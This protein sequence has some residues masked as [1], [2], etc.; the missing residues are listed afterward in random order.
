MEIIYDM[1]AKEYHD[2]PRFSSSGIKKILVSA[3]DFWVSSWMNPNRKEQTSD[4]FNV[5]TAYHTRILEGEEVFD[6]RYAV[7]PDVDRRTKDGK[8]TYLAWLEANPEA[9]A[10]DL[11][12]CVQIE[13][14]AHRL[15]ETKMFSDG[16]P[17]VSILWTDDETGVPMKARLDY[18]TDSRILDLKT[19]SNSQGSDIMRLVANHMIKYRYH[20]QAAIYNGLF[21]DREMLFVFQQTGDVN[22]FIVRSLPQETLI[23]DQGRK[24]ARQG[25]RKFA[26]M[27]RKYG[28]S[29]WYD[30][31]GI[32]KFD[33]MD[34]PLYALEE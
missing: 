29:P 30:D 14:A 34:F 5:G 16:K 31:F 18:L 15:E 25:I 21:P 22:N 4:T 7:A 32:G 24:L 19:F 27:Y 23:A 9:E 11:E 8:A 2:L 33:D 20:V 17:E 1:P 26:D 6:K 3:N 28:T 12:T 13:K 10:I